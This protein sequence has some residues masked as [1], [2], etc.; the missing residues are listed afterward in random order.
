MKTLAEKI[1][2]MQHVLNGGSVLINNNTKPCN[3][4]T[5]NWNDYDYSIYTPPKQQKKLYPALCTDS[6]G[7]YVTNTLYEKVIDVQIY[8]SIVIRLLTE[9]PPVIVD[10]D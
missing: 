7:Y 4:P 10:V 5:F 2:V 9:Y 1:A 8:S 3:H 6:Q